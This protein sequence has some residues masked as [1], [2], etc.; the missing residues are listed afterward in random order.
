[1]SN[2]EITFNP[3][4]G[5]KP[6]VGPIDKMPSGSFGWMSPNNLR[7]DCNHLFIQRDTVLAC[8]MSEAATLL[9]TKVNDE[10]HVHDLYVFMTNRWWNYPH[11][12]TY[13]YPYDY[14]VYVRSLVRGAERHRD[15]T[16]D[17]R[18]IGNCAWGM[19][20]GRF[21]GQLTSMPIG[22]FGF[23]D[24]KQFYRSNNCV[25]ITEGTQVY[26]TLEGETCLQVIRFHDGF[27]VFDGDVPQECRWWNR[28]H[29]AGE[30]RNG[31]NTH[32]RGL[33]RENEWRNRIGR[34]TA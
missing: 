30:S 8:E 18:V 20:Y 17:G 13:K 15:E 26:P 10:V 23:L 12:D 7:I 14:G 28:N 21:H 34:H 31:W 29:P 25:Y 1:M 4:D 24:M 27:F 22:C 5:L 32:V 19:T 11:L 16:Q 33:M 2:P 6:Y 3:L 9:A